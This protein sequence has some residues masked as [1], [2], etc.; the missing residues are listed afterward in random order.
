M[1]SKPNR[2]LHLKVQDSKT[3]LA[4][5]SQTSGI[6]LT[7]SVEGTGPLKE[8]QVMVHQ[9][10]IPVYKGELKIYFITHMAVLSACMSKHHVFSAQKPEDG[11]SAQSPWK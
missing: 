5:F 11:D 3:S 2:T 7:P 9:E 4:T 1:P 10:R 6:G 8:H